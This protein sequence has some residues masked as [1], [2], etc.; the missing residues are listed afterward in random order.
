MYKNYFIRHFLCVGLTLIG[1][2]TNKLEATKLTL[3]TTEAF[4]HDLIDPPCTQKIPNEILL[5]IFQVPMKG[6]LELLKNLRSVCKNFKQL[7]DENLIVPTWK[8]KLTRKNMKKI[9]EELSAFLDFS[10][11]RE[12][13]QLNVELPGR[14]ISGLRQLIE[15]TPF[16][17]T[18]LAFEGEAWGKKQ[19]DIEIIFSYLTKTSKLEQLKISSNIQYGPLETTPL[20]FLSNPFLKRNID[21]IKKLDIFMLKIPSRLPINFALNLPASVE[22]LSLET[23][24]IFNIT[25]DGT[26]R[27]KLEH[28]KI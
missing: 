5:T 16:P 18:Y 7:I 15:K 19:G 11:Q 22:T 24:V 8:N 20:K 26:K 21:G 10:K 13:F 28:K 6:H 23:N 4:P 25:Q 2:S 17:V 3:T 9:K 14:V 27:L 1:F 12:A